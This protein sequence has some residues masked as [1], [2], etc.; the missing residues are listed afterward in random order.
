VFCDKPLI[1]LCKVQMNHDLDR[2]EKKDA[3][4]LNEWAR[5]RRLIA[6]NGD[7][8]LAVAVETSEKC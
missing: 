4:A 1:S 7:R 2:W 8:S 3:V 6:A 5:G